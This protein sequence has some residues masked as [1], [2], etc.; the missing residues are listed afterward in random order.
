MHASQEVFKVRS[1]LMLA[2]AFEKWNPGHQAPFN[3]ANIT[4]IHCPRE[5]FVERKILEYEP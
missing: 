2:S 5:F 4:S 1:I 3:M